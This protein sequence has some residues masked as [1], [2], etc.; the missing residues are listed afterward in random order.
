VGIAWWRLSPLAWRW[1]VS[2]GQA[3]EKGLKA[4]LADHNVPFR[5]THSLEELLNQ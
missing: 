5:P 2:R 4:F 1:Q 3:G